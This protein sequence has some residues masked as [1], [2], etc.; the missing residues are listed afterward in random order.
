MS[1]S[2]EKSNDSV[3]HDRVSSRIAQQSGHTS[4]ECPLC[5]LTSPSSTE[6]CD[7]GYSF[8]TQ[9]SEEQSGLQA[10]TKS[11]LK[12]ELIVVLASVLAGVYIVIDSN[13]FKPW[14]VSVSILGLTGALIVPLTKYLRMRSRH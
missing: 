5:G 10:R 1:K 2:T 11:R 7:C 8:S 9:S 6:R 13:R 4:E 12:R 14:M 3:M